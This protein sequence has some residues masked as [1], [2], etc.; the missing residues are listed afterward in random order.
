MVNRLAQDFI[1]EY[2]RFQRINEQVKSKDSAMMAA[3]KGECVA[4][5]IFSAGAQRSCMPPAED[6]EGG[7]GGGKNGRGRAESD[8]VLRSLC[9]VC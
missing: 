5:L 6:L 9:R 8:G 2:K 3:V 7:R 4:S 1:K